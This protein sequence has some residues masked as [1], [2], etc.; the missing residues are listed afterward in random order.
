MKEKLKR[1]GWRDGDGEGQGG[2]VDG[3]EAVYSSMKPDWRAYLTHL[4]DSLIPIMDKG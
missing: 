1:I 2:A 4:W 3:N